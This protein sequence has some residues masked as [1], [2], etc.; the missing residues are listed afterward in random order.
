MNLL[1]IAV[2][3]NYKQLVRMLA[4]D[5]ESRDRIHVDWV[6]GRKVIGRNGSRYDDL[7]DWRQCGKDIL[8]KARSEGKLQGGPGEEAYRELEKAL[9]RDE[10]ARKGQPPDDGKD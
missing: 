2:E 6:I 5:C 10:E 8:V 3:R 7:I 4:S 9:E 1:Q